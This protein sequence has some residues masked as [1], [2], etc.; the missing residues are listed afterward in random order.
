MQRVGLS[1]VGV[2]PG[3]TMLSIPSAGPATT[4]AGPGGTDAR[5]TQAST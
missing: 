3:R 2:R 4:Y 1:G 5:L